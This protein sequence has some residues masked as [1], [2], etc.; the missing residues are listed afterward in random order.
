MKMTMTFAALALLGT[1]AVG[2]AYRSAEMWRDD[3]NKV[4][5]PKNNDIRACY[6]GVLKTTPTAAGKVTVTFEVE[7]D[8]GK[9]Q[10]VVVD[11]AGTTAPPEVGECVKKN[12]EGLVISPPDRRVGQATYVF[13]FSVPAPAA[14]KS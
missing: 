6:D 12:I 13:E 11:K 9:I 5:E 2:C 3:T 8:G 4:L 14:P 1:F 10:N 7:T